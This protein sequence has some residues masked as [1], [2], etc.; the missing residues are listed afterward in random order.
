MPENVSKVQA[1]LDFAFSGCKCKTG[2]TTRQFKCVKQGKSCG[3][4]CQC[5]NCHNLPESQTANTHLLN[6]LET[7]ER[8]EE[9]YGEEL[10]LV[11]DSDEDVELEMDEET[12]EIME[13]IFRIESADDMS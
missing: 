11:E 1:R 5:L 2:C 8:L 10:E 12:E 3:P 4:G 9:M 7:E 13:Y 6:E